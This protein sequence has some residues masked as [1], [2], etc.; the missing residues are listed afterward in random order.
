MIRFSIFNVLC[1]ENIP[2]WRANNARPDALLTW[3]SKTAG[4]SC[5]SDPVAIKVVI[6]TD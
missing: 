3:F 4:T 1:I 5:T 6:A 2:I